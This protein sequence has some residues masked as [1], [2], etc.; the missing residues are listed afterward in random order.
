[1]VNIEKSSNRN[2]AIL[3]LSYLA[4]A[5]AILFASYIYYKNYETQFRKDVEN[6]LTSI[7]EL[8]VDQIDKWRQERLNDGQIYQNN[9]VF[10][11]IA[12]NYFKDSTD[13]DA[14]ERLQAWMGQVFKISK[15]DSA[16]LLDTLMNIR[17]KFSNRNE[18]NRSLISNESMSILRSGRTVFEDFYKDTALDMIFLKILVP[19]FDHLESK[20]LI[21][22]VE[23]RINPC[24]FLYPMISDWP[25][26]SKTSE[27][28]I[29]RRD[30]NDMLYLNELKFQSNTA[31]NLRFPLTRTELPA[32]KAV[33]GQQ[34]I[35]EGTDYRGVE[36]FACLKQIPRSPWYMV[37]RIDKDEVYAPLHEKVVFLYIIAIVL[38]FA[39]TLA[40]TLISRHQRVTFY[41]DKYLILEKL[42]Q[43]EEDFAITLN[44]IGDGVISTDKEGNIVRMNPVAQQMCGWS[45]DEAKGKPLTE[46]FKIVNAITRETVVNPVEKV[47]EKGMIIGLANH[48]VLISK[49]GSEYQIADSAAPIKKN[50]GS[51]FG[52]VL[53]F[54]DVTES[55][56]VQDALKESEKR[57]H[58]LFESMTEGVALHELVY[59]IDGNP[60]DYKIIEINPAFEMHTGIRSERAVNVLSTDLYKTDTPP[61]FEI[62][63][64][65]ALTGKPNAFE[66]YFPPLRKHFTITVFSPLKG[67]FAT[68]FEDITDRKRS[69]QNLL[70]SEEKFRTIAEN[71]ADVIYM[72]DENG[73]LTY[74]SP[75]TFS[76]FG[77]L[78]EEIE[79]QF[80]GK[81]LCE[82]E[83]QEVIP[84]FYDIVNSGLKT[85]S[86]PIKAKHKDGNILDVEISSSAI[87]KNN[88][89]IGTLGLIHDVTEKKK[90]EDA[91]RESEAFNRRMIE[92]ANE[93]IWSMDANDKT[94][95]INKR[96]AD[97]L[98]YSSEEMIEKPG[99]DFIFPDDMD[100]YFIKESERRSGSFGIYERRLKDKNGNEVWTLVSSSPIYDDKGNY[101]GSFGM[102][103]DISS[104]KHAE[105]RVNKLNRIYALLSN[106]NQTIVRISDKDSLFNEICRIAVEDGHFRMTWIGIINKETNKI[107]VAA[108]NGF[109]GDYLD[110]INIDLNDK[111][112]S[113]GP[114]GQAILTGKINFCND[115]RNDN[116]M[117]S[118]QEE[119]KKLGFKSAISV[120]L[121]V[122]DEVIGAFTLY[123]NEIGFFDEEEIK[124]LE[125]M[126]MDISFALEF[127]NKELKSKLAE[128]ALRES[129]E[130]FK[131]IANYT[132][133]WES[134]FGTDGKYLWVNEGVERITGYTAN[135][136]MEMPDFIQI[137]VAPDDREVFINHFQDALNGISGENYEFR[138]IHKN[139]SVRWLNMS[140][141]QIFDSKGN[142]LGIRSSGKDITD[143]KRIDE[144]QMFLLQCGYQ[145][146]DKNFFESLAKYLADT[147]E[148]DYICIDRL[149]GDGLSAQTVAVYY[150]GNIK[151]N[152]SY[153]L[154]DTPCGDVIGK[155]ICCFPQNVRSLFPK[156]EALQEM[157]AESYIGTTLWSTQGHPIGLIAV[158]GRKPLANPELAESILKLV[159]VRAAGE[160][161]NRQAEEEINEEKLFSEMLIESLPGIF[162]MFDQDMN[163]LRWN[164]NK[165]ILLGLNS[166]EMRKHSTIEFIADPD[167]DKLINSIKK[168]FTEGE[169]QALVSI[170][171]YDGQ[172][173]PY[174]LTGKRID[175]AK[176]PMLLGVGIDISERIKAE[177]ELIVALKKAEESDRLKSAFLA[178]MSHEIRTPMNG[179]I[180]FSKILSSLGITQD[181]R[182]E[183]AK[184]LSIS[185]NR[186]LKIVNDVLDISKI[187]SGQMEV[188]QS[189]FSIN[190]LIYEIYTFNLPIFT[191][192]NLKLL[193]KLSC[194]DNES[195][196]IGD[197]QKVHQILSILLNNS[198]KFTSVGYVE[199]GYSKS[200]DNFEFYVKDTG[201][202]IAVEAQES[203]FGRFQQEDSSISRTHEGA[204]LGL[205]IAKGM[206]ELIGGIIWVESKKAEGS[207]FKFTIPNKGTDENLNEELEV[208]N[209][210]NIDFGSLK[211]L[212]VEDDSVSYYLV[213]RILTK[214]FKVEVIWAKDGIEAIE[215]IN[216]DSTISLILMDVKMPGMDGLT[217]TRKIK[218]INPDIPI[219]AVTA[220]AMG[221]DQTKALQAGCDDYLSKPIDADQLVQKMNK[222]YRG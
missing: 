170:I 212:V 64:E 131:A 123:S 220:F 171:K 111:T 176:G 62:Y 56:A 107:D 214:D 44:S 183:Y 143:R 206:T 25:T 12:C 15:Y 207:I 194:S 140:W 110:K 73:I 42:R 205:A 146:Q 158:I 7:A 6:Q 115:I 13:R 11:K 129:E 182:I 166:Q 210:L 31:L 134:W 191:E 79:D 59:A 157:V 57:F 193:P 60:I 32:V 26:T 58:S 104:R 132:L 188:R 173:V 199:F 130:K 46:V 139:G 40:V 154:V 2:R 145:D 76:T 10:S 195:I 91:L 99:T 192:R 142:P 174:H 120:P 179:I 217:A 136:I 127:Y 66:S 37:A 78:P 61:Y 87:Y 102:F 47:I 155:T 41:K 84:L 22:I 114:T 161:E 196:V 28:L 200:K 216:K 9:L 108:S 178:N 35:V 105:D 119:A 39:A 34:G 48:T 71:L 215:M 80:F 113:Q 177:D 164:R 5:V 169:S 112:Q 4:C 43:S 72:T 103:S 90:G 68:V 38:F 14:I 51:I 55:Y 189:A 75:S 135:E 36:V 156:D 187:E 24:E 137:V 180:G 52:V 219:I 118:W 65:V 208:N 53:V 69:E 172:L 89:V 74:L 50:D 81:F 18:A 221:D 20:K 117:L 70:V 150:D 168:I 122:S 16:F 152:I 92:N 204:G 175:T 163:I 8:K 19:V 29:L 21:A 147:L 109:T 54:S 202:G 3:L 33:L 198:L 45:L 88:Q 209:N 218:S 27:T 94:V 82:E 203:I 222:W 98:G 63:K 201:I 125:E 23:L 186:L 162:Y 185:C 165:E 101:A 138:Y 148:M 49:N 141:Q 67:T 190:K 184:I 160:L 126:A 153:S 213:E 95:F 96:M 121:I 133:G 159:T 1:M 128:E 85:K 77:Y 149:I 116:R 86:V 151:D 181:E 167:K 211:L 17:F 197:E 144:A 100:D 93:G 30:G 106:V 83:L 97:L 124:L